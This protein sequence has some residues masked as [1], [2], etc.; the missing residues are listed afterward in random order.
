MSFFGMV[1]ANNLGEIVGFVCILIVSSWI[2]LSV[3]RRLE[4]RYMRKIGSGEWQS[5][6]SDPKRYKASRA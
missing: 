5:Y 2:F 6:L 4:R 1:I 3:G